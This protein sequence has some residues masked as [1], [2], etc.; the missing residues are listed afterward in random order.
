[1]SHRENVS[2]G[3]T[4]ALE[5]LGQSTCVHPVCPLLKRV[6]T[7]VSSDKSRLPLSTAL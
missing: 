6:G 5:I 4:Y 2:V 7:S 1:M 3:M